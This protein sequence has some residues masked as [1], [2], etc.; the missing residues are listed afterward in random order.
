MRAQGVL[1]EHSDCVP[2]WTKPPTAFGLF[3]VPICSDLPASSIP[4]YNATR[5][6]LRIELPLSAEKRTGP[7]DPPT[8]RRR[9]RVHQPISVQNNRTDRVCRTADPVVSRFGLI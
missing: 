7:H 4:R 9:R 2:P 8:M 6:P 5:H 3:S 1:P